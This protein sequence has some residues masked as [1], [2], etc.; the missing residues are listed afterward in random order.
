MD[1]GVDNTSSV[2][3]KGSEGLTVMF[4]LMK[5]TLLKLL[6]TKTLPEKWLH[7]SFILKNKFILLPSNTCTRQIFSFNFKVVAF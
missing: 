4:G 2:A 6:K 5:V 3:G 1:G 7:I